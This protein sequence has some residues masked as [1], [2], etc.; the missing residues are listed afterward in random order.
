MSFRLP[1]AL[2]LYRRYPYWRKADCIFIHI[3]KAAGTTIN[4]AL[5]GR[6]LGH[7]T[8]AEIA[9]AF[10]GLARRCFTFAAVRDPYDRLYSAYRFA[11][12]GRTADMGITHPERYRTP[13][14]DTF[15]RFIHDWLVHQDLRVCDHV[16]RPQHHYVCI[17]GRVAVDA[18]VKV[19]RLAEEIPL[20]EARIG[21]RIPLRP[22]NVNAPGEIPAFTR[23]M[24]ER[25]VELYGADFDLLGYDREPA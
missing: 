11:K 17:D 13:E 9:G 8:M 24:R 25:V 12:A 19:E 7:Y 3:P 1:H 22:R 21:R 16:F 15:E 2:N 10:P 4:H 5:Y 20:V 6:T 18:I 14:F 23:S